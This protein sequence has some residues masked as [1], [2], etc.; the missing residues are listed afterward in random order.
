MRRVP[1]TTPAEVRASIP[2]VTAHLQR[3]GLIAYPTETVYGFGGLVRDDAL[4][5]LSALKSR[6]ESKPFLLLIRAAADLPALEWTPSA[7]K[8]AERFWPGP[9]TLALRVQGELPSRILSAE[10]TLAVR[11]TPHEG[12]RTL[13]EA[14]DEPITS[15]SANPPR[16][17]TAVSADEVEQVLRELKHEEVLILD[18]GELA[19]SPPSTLVDCSTEPPRIVRVGVITPEALRQIVELQPQ[20]P[21]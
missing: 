4:A 9:L 19:P 17:A 21:V 20:G 15:S 18:G 10:G 11:A 2:A 1:F 7:R 3:G 14:L 5:S 12:I 8:L 13:L 16:S 6:D